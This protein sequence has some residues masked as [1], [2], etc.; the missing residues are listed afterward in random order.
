MEEFNRKKHWE[1]IYQTKELMEVSWIRSIPET[2]LE[3]FKHFKVPKN[4][5]VI[6]IG[7][8]VVIW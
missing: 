6:D 7:G 3:F 8:G 4:A 1:H 2:F 5:K